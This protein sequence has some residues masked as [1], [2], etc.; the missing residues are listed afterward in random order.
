MPQWD[1]EFDNEDEWSAVGAEPKLPERSSTEAFVSGIKSLPRN[2][3]TTLISTMQSDPGASA[4]NKGFLDKWY[5]RQQDKNIEEQEQFTGKFIP[6]IKD[7]DVVRGIQG[8]PYTGL[9]A[10]GAVVAGA[11]GQATGIPGAQIAGGIAGSALLTHRATSYDAMT[12]SLE[13][14]NEIN[15]EETGKPIT[16]EQENQYKD[17]FADD[18]S[19]IANWESGTETASTMIELA[20]YGLGGKF[21]PPAIKKKAV[22]TAMESFKKRVAQG[23]AKNVK[24]G[25]GTLITE[26]AEEVVSEI[27]GGNIERRM[28][29]E[30]EK[31]WNIPTIAQTAK[32]VAPVVAVTAGT[33]HGA[34]TTYGVIDKATG[35]GRLSPEEEQAMKQHFGKAGIAFA[36]KNP[37]KA[38]KMLEKISQSGKDQQAES[39]Q[40]LNDIL[41]K[42]NVSDDAGM[43]ESITNGF[44]SGE[45]TEDDISTLGESQP[46][47]KPMLN[48]IV[49]N[50]LKA[51]AD[52]DAFIKEQRAKDDLETQIKK[53]ATDEYRQKEVS[54]AEE[55][56][57]AFKEGIPQVPAAEAAQIFEETGE[58]IQA[59]AKERQK[60]IDKTYLPAE[61][62]LDAIEFAKKQKAKEKTKETITDRRQATIEVP[63]ERRIEDR[64]K[65]V[66]KRKRVADMT[67]E[68]A[69]TELKTSHLTGL[70]NK[71]AYEET[72]KKTKQTVIDVDSLKF[73]ND[74]YGHEN[75]DALLKHV[76]KAF[77]G[78]QDAFH[79]SGDEFLV[80]GDTDA[81]VEAA[82][83]KAYDYLDKNPL[84]I[85]DENSKIITKIK[86]SFSYGTGKT[87]QEADKALRQQKIDREISGDRATR[88]EKP[89]GITEVVPEG[90]VKDERGGIKDEVVEPAKPKIKKVESAKTPSPKIIKV[91]KIGESE[92]A[93][94][95]EVDSVKYEL[96]KQKD[97]DKGHIRIFDS[98]SGEVVDNISFP[99]FEMAE[100]KFAET[101]KIV[102]K[103][104]PAKPKEKKPVT[105]PSSKIIKPTAKPEIQKSTTPKEPTPE[106]K[107]TS[108]ALV[109]PPEVTPGD[110]K[111]EAHRPMT[112]ESGAARLTDLTPAFGKDIYSKKAVQLFGTGKDALDQITVKILQSVKGKP[113]QK[114]TVYRAIEKD[115]T[116]IKLQEGDWVTVNK[117]YAKEHGESILNGDYKIIE[118]TIRVKDLTTNV[119]SFHEQ[120]YYPIPEKPPA[121][122]ELKFD[123][124]I[125]IMPIGQVTSGEKK[126]IPKSKAHTYIFRGKTHTVSK[127]A[128]GRAFIK[129]QQK[130]IFSQR[131]IV[132]G[133]NKGKYQVL[134]SSGKVNTKG[135]KI[136]KAAFVDADA[137]VKEAG[138]VKVKEEI[139]KKFQTKTAQPSANITKKALKDIFSGMKN[140]TTG[141]TKSG[142][143]FFRVKGRKAVVIKEVNFIDGY[144]ET[145]E[146]E[147]IPVGSFLKNTIE[148]KTGGKG[149]TADLTTVFH[150]LCHYLE[151]N[152]II[153]SNDIKTL[154]RAIANSKGINKDDVTDEQ[155]ADYVGN[156]LAEWTK[157]K[158]MRIRRIL[159]KIINFM[160]AIYE[161]V[162]QTR[163]ARGVLADVESGKITRER[164]GAAPALKPATQASMFQTMSKELG[165]SEEQLKKEFEATKAKYKGTDEW[166]K[167]PNGKPSNLNEH[168]WVMTRT[169]RF[170]EW[171]SGSKVIDENGEPLIVYRGDMQPVNE[172]KESKLEIGT[173]AL[174][175]GFYF[176]KR[177]QDAFEYGEV[178]PFYL[179]MQNPYI[180]DAKGR[181]IRAV[182]PEISDDA[183]SNGYDGVVLN[184]IVDARGFVVDDTPK[185]QYIAFN[186]T[187]IKSIYNTGAFDPDVGDIR[188]Q[189]TAPWSYS[190]LL[191]IVKM[192]FSTLP[193][194]ARSIVPWLQKKQVKPAEIAWMGIEDWIKDNQKDGVID[195][196]AFKQ[197]VQDNQLKIQEVEK[198]RGDV[199]D[200]DFGFLGELFDVVYPD[201]YRMVDLEDAEEFVET[202]LLSEDYTTNEVFEMWGKYVEYQENKDSEV[203]TE[204][205]QYQEPGGEDYKEL[206]FILPDKK[207]KMSFSSLEEVQ[208]KGKQYNLPDVE[209]IRFYNE[210]DEDLLNRINEKVGQ[211]PQR[212]AE[213]GIYQSQHYD[214]TNVLLHI[215]HN[216]RI[217]QDGNKVLFIEEVQSDWLQEAKEKGFALSVKE[218]KK[219]EKEFEKLTKYFQKFKEKNIPVR[220]FL[221]G[222]EKEMDA[223]GKK[224]KSDPN[225]NRYKELE[226]RIENKSV[227]PR[228][229]LLDT[230]H[231]YALK[232]TLRYA[233]EN[234]FDKVAWTSGKMQID[235]YDEALRQNVDRIRWKRER[236]PYRDNKYRIKVL[237]FKNDDVVF[238]HLIPLE[239][240]TTINNKKVDLKDVIGKNLADKIRQSKETSG[241]FEDNDLSIGGQGMKSFYDEKLPGFLKKYGKQWKAKLGTVEAEGLKTPVQAINITP[242]MKHSVMFEGQRQ[243]QVSAW[244][245]SPSAG[246]A[247]GY[248]DEFIGTGE[249]AQAFGYGHYF[250]SLESIAKG[251][252]KALSSGSEKLYLSGKY[253]KKFNSVEVSA[254]EIAL[255]ENFDSVDDLLMY[256]KGKVADTTAWSLDRETYKTLRQKLI[257]SKGK[258]KTLSDIKIKKDRN[259]YKVTLFKDKKPGE[260]EWLD[261]DKKAT[262][263]QLRAVLTQS[264][265]ENVVSSLSV[266]AFTNGRIERKGNGFVKLDYS[267]WTPGDAPKEISL[268]RRAAIDFINEYTPKNMT[269]ITG[270]ALYQDLTSDFGTKKEASDFLLRADIDGIRY[271]VGS[272]SG[273]K[274]KGGKNYVVFDPKAITIEEHKQFQLAGKKALTADTGAL[275]KAKK[276]LGKGDPAKE[277]WEDTGWTQEASGKF[278]FR[279]DDSKAKIIYPV[280]QGDIASAEKTTLYE[281]LTHPELFAAYPELKKVTVSLFVAPE[282]E[283]NGSFAPAEFYSPEYD[284]AVINISAP[285]KKAAHN[286]LLHEISHAI[287][288]IEGF[289]KG[290]APEA[291]KTPA[292]DEAAFI[293]EDI[294]GFKGKISD[295]EE[296]LALL[297]I[298]SAKGL[299]AELSDLKIALKEKQRTL[300][301]PMLEGSE[302][303]RLAYKRLAG[304]IYAREAGEEYTGLPGTME[305]IPREEWIIQDGGGTSFSVEEPEAGKETALLEGFRKGYAETLKPVTNSDFIENRKDKKNLKLIAKTTTRHVASE[306]AEGLDK[307]FGPISTRL[308]NISK[309]LKYKVRQLDIDVSKKY[310]DNVK[311]VKPLLKKAKR[312]T[313]DDF[314]DWDYARKN[315]VIWKIEELI[316]K[317]DMQTEYDAYRKTLNDIRNEGIDVGL[318]IG[319]IE[320]YAPRILKDDRGFLLEIGKPEHRPLYSDKLKE[321]A[322]D[323]GITVAEMPLDMKANLISNIILG[324]WTGMY[325]IS[326]T[327]QRKLKKIP[328]NLNKFYMDSDSALMQH[329][330]TMRK[331]IEARKFFGK[332][333]VK[334]VEMRTR[335]HVVQSGIRE[336]NKNMDGVLTEGQQKSIKRLQERL[337]HEKLTEKERIPI[338]KR[339]ALL[340]S[341]S[342]GTMADE[343]V[344]D[345]RKKR[346][347]QIG[348]EK[349]YTAYLEKYAMQR[350]Y[351]ENIGVYVMELIDKGEIK[352]RDERRVN[353]I[354]NAR[355]HEAGTRGVIQAYKNISYI[356]TMGSPISAITQIGDLAWSLYAGGA[357]PTLKNAS[358]SLLG[359][360]RITK[361]DVGINKIAQEFA[362][363]GTLSSAV[364]WVFK[365]VG[366]E[367]MDSIGKEALLNTAFEQYQKEAK[368]NPGKLKRKIKPIFEN[369][370]DSVIEDLL[371]NEVTDNV[372]LL[373]Y[374]RL[375]DF[376][377]VGL[378]EMPQK[379]LDAG[380]GRLF[381][382]LKTFTIKSFDVFRNEAY[383]KIKSKDKSERKEGMKNL[384]KL[385][386]FFVLANAG[387]DEIKDLILGRK[388][389]WSDRFT[390]NI[391]RLFGVS[392]FVT[393]KARTEGVGSALSRQILPPFKFIDSL[394][395]DI[396]T[397]GDEKG[398]ET[399][400]S[401]PIV[402]K[403]AYWHIG[404]GTSKRS[405]LWDRRLRKRKAKLN[406]IKDRFE[407][408]KNKVAYRRK[409]RQELAELRRINTLQG[410]LNK[411]KKRINR[412]KGLKETKAGKLKIQELENIR[413]ELI[414]KFLKRERE[415]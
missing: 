187:Q 2:I 63:Q 366:L 12:R 329:L 372:K 251:Y 332:I 225:W 359:R 286:A 112:V 128:A 328:P 277:V 212:D 343:L 295:L 375:L 168:L 315:S 405:D 166:M 394:G 8:L 66:F 58:P 227:I 46:A 180:Y 52:A 141:Q 270:K 117:Q 163:T 143:L 280:D 23:V 368:K 313:K 262:T 221:A 386:A 4:V 147:R 104:L 76:G 311:A 402:G 303:K 87:I 365:W 232:R 170:K 115:V 385:A 9:A 312:M 293:I 36:N 287:Q 17:L 393:W 395:K 135:I 233:A 379:Y 263:S 259:L 83:Q 105:E 298:E 292:G 80:Q 158:N 26:I 27:G 177:K 206:V 28:W 146:D 171:F 116:T 103:K 278:A 344:D 239:G 119:D 164:E 5:K 20:I 314:I 43:I 188:Y 358:K 48:D 53:E 238:N 7:V 347:K 257:V 78:N 378:S 57:Q 234:D 361:E 371:N 70:G 381:Y 245:G 91:G 106:A 207:P 172:Y 373:V 174:G 67:L 327:K 301:K 216:T 281:V 150:E 131:L 410:E 322:R 284:K 186:P 219:L 162:A 409:H 397:V 215:R 407:T 384:V 110:V 319:Q 1:W 59:A 364:A 95:Q 11:A 230:W 65:D 376:Q 367:K 325:G 204:F 56:A 130:P 68:E 39:L 178:N 253:I 357:I 228:A 73:V 337:D 258:I 256:L 85:V 391:L 79:L 279:I 35:G 264:I 102:K 268:S 113:E 96:Y 22:K 297:P 153:N 21:F 108:K 98:E 181:G 82:M 201:G 14:L 339:I 37:R 179:N 100:L 44:T 185:T 360:S 235:R 363:P 276:R 190:Q 246:A 167:A 42:D 30:E 84:E 74:T 198:D 272:L 138:G 199:E 61:Q 137:I 305:G 413:T 324:G 90:E 401:V 203:A 122:V 124:S 209:A 34:G 304:E 109:K 13:R 16:L 41:A 288:E 377:P 161:F 389:D 54:T 120:G 81:D 148:L 331:G 254:L 354:L 51:D 154:N 210:T 196:E 309:K 157:H 307:F 156:N 189:S 306:I 398:L 408:T 345:I 352:A 114:I 69:R 213:R 353:E 133:K 25:A 356:D 32:E 336:L 144:I 388:T 289:A 243:F 406:K 29:G 200:S 390:D 267:K 75:G 64:R 152:N 86:G 310:A 125:N 374:N 72:G 151:N 47:L 231:E 400:G 300:K 229:P 160:N 159:K 334:V 3:G 342:T 291:M 415:K 380:N 273:M 155:R 340:T 383:N 214:E 40:K 414:K 224:V 396:I 326:A 335:L 382:M 269:P 362:D 244:Q 392:K 45:L 302:E 346:N 274:D 183:R 38:R 60:I 240:T 275:F 265:T 412:L 283:L 350:D 62:E 323:M 94:T 236:E 97:G 320:E 211:E 134:F 321:H 250:S 299:R 237:A 49:A 195:K 142:D 261:W 71:R 271:P 369:E 218:T 50:K 77:E 197:F 194:K 247:K 127:D 252:A 24:K 33:I 107:K 123:E 176:T 118:Q 318:S 316:K 111:K 136:A 149:A 184:N 222:M 140:I 129:D 18:I 182:Q 255:R 145:L 165:I 139:G 294:K 404:R 93:E 260:Y 282:L 101:V 192:N 387:A 333:P 241:K 175:G 126:S 341:I 338:K 208:K 349:Q 99:S 193:K 348:L 202:N 223:Y 217:D 370:T 31:E 249:G 330:H 285:N 19:G 89:P 220:G 399:L 121:K 226:K 290:G 10:T 132:S 169:P 6:G 308:G 173:Q 248:S 205:S 55:A 296:T 92:I 242:E 191:K 88:G 351:T 403:L 355:F 266:Q 317:Y 15:L 411:Y